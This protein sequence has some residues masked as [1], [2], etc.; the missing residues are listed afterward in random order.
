[1]VGI[2]AEENMLMLIIL[3]RPPMPPF[4]G[5]VLLVTQMR[6]RRMHMF[7]SFFIVCNLEDAWQSGIQRR[8]PINCQKK[9]NNPCA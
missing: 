4:S 3:E 5:L 7:I 6:S 1:M 8:R 9:S 2:D